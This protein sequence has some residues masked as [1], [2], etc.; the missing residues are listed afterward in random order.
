[1]TCVVCRLNG[2]RGY[3]AESAVAFMSLSLPEHVSVNARTNAVG[4]GTFARKIKSARLTIAGRV[5]V[6]DK[7][8]HK[9]PHLGARGP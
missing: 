3:C 1:M 9:R 8:G 7:F 2:K 6:R 5:C 4:M